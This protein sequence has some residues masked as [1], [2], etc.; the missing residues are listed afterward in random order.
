MYSTVVPFEV[1]RYLAL[2]RPE[3][4]LLGGRAVLQYESQLATDCDPYANWDYFAGSAR[5]LGLEK[6][7]TLFDPQIVFSDEA[8]NLFFR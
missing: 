8:S 6:G 7:E 2:E 5:S 4:S 3:I 1:E